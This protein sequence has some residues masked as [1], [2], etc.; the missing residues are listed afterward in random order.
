MSTPWQ[1]QHAMDGNEAEAWNDV[2]RIV[3]LDH[4]RCDPLAA[5]LQ[6]VCSK[7][8]LLWS[9]GEGRFAVEVNVE[10]RHRSRY[11]GGAAALT[12]KEQHEWELRLRVYANAERA[13]TR[14]AVNSWTA[15]L[16]SRDLGHKATGR[17][18]QLQIGDPEHL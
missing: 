16:H 5:R 4:F 17:I 15:D 2:L 6:R 10:R 9:I 12:P 7:W 18:F 8:R 11:G 14:Y 3:A 13:K 1:G